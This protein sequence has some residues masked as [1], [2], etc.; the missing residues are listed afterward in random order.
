MPDID[1]TV[2]TDED[3]TSLHSAVMR[4]MTRRQTLAEA[5]TRT[6]EIAAALA[7][8]G[9]YGLIDDNLASLWEVLGAAVLGVA[10]AH[11]GGVYEAPV[12]GVPVDGD[13]AS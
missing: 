10:T 5:E 7:L 3:L 1:L 11:T 8:A 13:G 6:T 9:A 2:L 12:D 4:E